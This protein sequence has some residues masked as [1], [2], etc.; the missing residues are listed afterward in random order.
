M[1]VLPATA[2]STDPRRVFRP[3]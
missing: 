1:S 2:R 3:R